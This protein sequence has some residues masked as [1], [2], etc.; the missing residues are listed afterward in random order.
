MN[1][2]F[3]IDDEGIWLNFKT[4]KN[5][6]GKSIKVYPVMHF[7]EAE[8]HGVL[9]DDSKDCEKILLENIHAI[10]NVNNEKF[11]WIMLLRS[12]TV[13]AYQN[14]V[15][16]LFGLS[17]QSDLHTI[18]KERNNTKS[19]D[20][21]LNDAG[22]EFDPQ[23]EYDAA[24]GDL[25]DL[26]NLS[27]NY[28]SNWL[29]NLLIRY[30]KLYDEIL[31]ATNSAANS[32]QGGKISSINS[33]I[34]NALTNELKNH[35]KIGAVFGASHIIPIGNALYGNGFYVDESSY[36]LF[37]SRRPSILSKFFGI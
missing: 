33:I 10:E 24:I 23:K 9:Y 14:I 25:N 19:I 6:Q 31:D 11:D 20:I 32:D 21:L 15:P 3:R 4:Y 37:L 28:S 8:F 5:N 36:H 26:I 22:S 18:L 34:Y 2:F 13:K 30:N 27:A 7:T 29:D 16:L 17:Q 35:K 12:K 1:D